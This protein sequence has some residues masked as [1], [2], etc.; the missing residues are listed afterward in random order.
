MRRVGYYYCT[1]CASERL[2]VLWDPPWDEYTCSCSECG[3]Q[4]GKEG[5]MITTEYVVDGAEVNKTVVTK[6][7]LDAAVLAAGMQKYADEV[8]EELRRRHGGDEVYRATLRLHRG[9]EAEDPATRRHLLNS[10]APS[11]M[12]GKT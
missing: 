6:P 11:L 5:Y 9:L 12:S 1:P 7:A 10:S 4:F 8:A 3:F 2:F